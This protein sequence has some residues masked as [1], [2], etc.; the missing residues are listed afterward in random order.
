MGVGILSED[1]PLESESVV[2]SREMASGVFVGVSFAGDTEVSLSLFFSTG[3]DKVWSNADR[4]AS[5][6]D[7]EVT[8]AP[9]SVPD[10]PFG[11]CE[12]EVLD[13]EV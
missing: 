4:A 5:V 8:S 9:V 13:E 11:W 12:T 3:G 10:D 7:P 6:S 2:K 1:S